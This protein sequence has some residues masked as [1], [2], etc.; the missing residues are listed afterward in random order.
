MRVLSGLLIVALAMVVAVGGLVVVQSLY[1]TERRKQHNDVA[2][3]IYAVLGVSYGPNRHLCSSSAHCLT[4]LSRTLLL[5]GRWVN[6]GRVE[7]APSLRYEPPVHHLYEIPQLG[8]RV[9]RISQR[10]NSPVSGDPLQEAGVVLEREICG[11]GS[12]PVLRPEP[13]E[14][15]TLFVVRPSCSPRSICACLIQ[16][17]RVWSAMPSS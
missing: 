13:T 6:R 9:L 5:L 12:D 16:L 17:R 8:I 3:F 2:G 15:L 4:R 7:A 14:L 11:V 10:H 1:S